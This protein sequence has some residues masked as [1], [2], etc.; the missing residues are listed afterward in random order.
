MKIIPRFLC[1]RVSV[2]LAIYIRD[3]IPFRFMIDEEFPDH[4]F[5]FGNKNGSWSTDVLSK[6]FVDETETELNFRITWQDYRHIAKAIDRRF[7]RSGSALFDAEDDDDFDENDSTEG[8][9]SDIHDLMQG[10]SHSVAENVYARLSGITRSLTAESIDLFREVSDKW[11]KWLGLVSRQPMEDMPDMKI[12][13]QKSEKPI[14]TQLTD[15]MH[16]LYGASEDWRSPVQKE[17]VMSVVKGIS[18][19]FIILPTGYGKSAAFMLPAMLKRAG[20]TVVIS[21]LVALAEKMAELCKDLNMDY[22][23]YGKTPPRMARIVI[24]TADMAVGKQF[25]Q[26]ATDIKMMGK[27][28]RIVWDEIHKWTTDTYRP[29][30]MEAG[31]WPLGVQEIFLTATSPPYLQKK[32]IQSWKI[33]NETIIRI[34]NQKPK[35]RYTVMIFEDEDFM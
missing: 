5:L 24:V 30:L 31:N 35:M 18:P 4:G 17:A 14:E 32:M 29:K 34:P 6:V 9:F 19:L 1:H 12:E 16:H 3:V 22:I 7:I 10:H 23:W 25:N 15:A 8:L 21:P 11:H 27:L 20:V 13:E 33:R 2:M 28:D 26:Y